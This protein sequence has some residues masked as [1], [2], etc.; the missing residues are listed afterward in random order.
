MRWFPSA[1]R[2]V[3]LFLTVV[4]ACMGVFFIHCGSEASRARR[5]VV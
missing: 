3:A 2:G 1:S 4:G 5:M